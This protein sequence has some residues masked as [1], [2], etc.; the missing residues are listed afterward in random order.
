MN[1]TGEMFRGIFQGLALGQLFKNFFVNGTKE[2]LMQTV[3]NV[4]YK[5]VL[6]YQRSQ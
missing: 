5:T 4:H 6:H 2:R 3:A 1:Q